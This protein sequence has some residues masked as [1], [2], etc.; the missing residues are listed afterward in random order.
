MSM[1]LPGIPSLIVWKHPLG[2][3]IE[4]FLER[5]KIGFPKEKF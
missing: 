3:P 2:F 5:I 4:F 1:G